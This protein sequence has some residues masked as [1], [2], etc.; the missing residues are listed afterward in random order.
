MEEG[1]GKMPL[2]RIVT[3]QDV[4]P[5]LQARAREM[6]RRMTPAEAR[7]QIRRYHREGPELMALTQVH[8]L[9]HLVRYY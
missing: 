8:T 5:E 3:G 9:T 7:E 6:R 1:T 2:K 4:P